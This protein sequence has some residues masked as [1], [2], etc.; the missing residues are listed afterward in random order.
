M[1]KIIEKQKMELITTFK[2]MVA[3]VKKHPLAAVV[4]TILSTAW[5]Y[6]GLTVCEQVYVTTGSLK[7][8]IITGLSSV[9]TLVFIVLL[10]I[11]IKELREASKETRITGKSQ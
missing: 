11:Q 6:Y 3:D 7:D 4:Y 9:G 1:K 2:E 10:L 8:T 5:L